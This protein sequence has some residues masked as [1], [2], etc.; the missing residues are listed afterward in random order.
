MRTG[1]IGIK[2]IQ[3]TKPVPSW[4]RTEAWRNKMRASRERFQSVNNAMANAVIGAQG[5]LASGGAELAIRAAT[6]RMQD[7]A[8][9]RLEA[10]ADDVSKRLDNIKT[11]LTV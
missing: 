4:K 7:A 5:N 10:N 6:K 9:K 11:D 8:L 2:R 1:S 3:W